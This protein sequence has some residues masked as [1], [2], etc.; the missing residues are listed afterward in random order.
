M[1]DS[2]VG[3]KKK[4]SFKAPKKGTKKRKG[5]GARGKYLGNATADCVILPEIARRI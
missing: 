3:H 1:E 5:E 2:A 4:V